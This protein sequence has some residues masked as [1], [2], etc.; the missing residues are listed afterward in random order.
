V[1][2]CVLSILAA[3]GVDAMTRRWTTRPFWRRVIVCAA[4]IGIAVEYANRPVPLS[5]GI[6]TAP[7]EL[8]KALA[9]T[10]PG[11]IVELPLPN[12]E[13]LPGYD[14][15]YEAWSVW[16]WRPML[17]GYSGF[18]NPTYLRELDTLRRFPDEASLALLRKLGV[19][20]VIVHRAFFEKG[21]YLPLALKVAATSDLK[22]WGVYRER[23][24]PADILELAR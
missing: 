13:A 22:L 14:P 5:Y 15:Y 11:P 24:G 7:D 18:Y 9:T 4:L 23:F 10:E 21:E 8:Y 12:P 16:H 17:N 1:F 20:Y 19:R 2:G 6:G 3:L